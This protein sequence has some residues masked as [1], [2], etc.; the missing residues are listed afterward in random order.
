M[1]KTFSFR[2]SNV[3]AREIKVT[4]ETDTHVITNISFLGGCA[5]NTQGV[6]RLSVG[7]T[8]EEVS[9]S[10]SGIK[11]PGSRTRNTSCPDQLSIAIQQEI[12]R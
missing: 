2:P 4:Y 6:A 3:C 5:G 11:C 8:L 1:E 7:K 12:G 9:S 10:L